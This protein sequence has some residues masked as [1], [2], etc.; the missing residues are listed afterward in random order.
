[1]GRQAGTLAAAAARAN[2]EG[3]D[4]EDAYREGE[5]EGEEYE[6][7][8]GCDAAT[9]AFLGKSRKEDTRSALEKEAGVSSQRS[10]PTLGD[11]QERFPSL[12]GAPTVHRN[13]SKSLVVSFKPLGKVLRNTKCKRC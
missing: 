5:G 2:G 11:L 8:D 4:D 6:D 10:G 1:M 3:D 7:D 12:K 9:R 13:A